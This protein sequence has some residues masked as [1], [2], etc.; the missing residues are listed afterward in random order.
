MKRKRISLTV[1]AEPYDE[2]RRLTK[3]IGWRDNW[4]GL[5]IDKMVAGALKVAAQAKIDAQK[6]KPDPEEDR[7]S[8]YEE[9]MRDAVT[10]K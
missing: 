10:R 8:R 9:I 1:N 3:E 4:L 7:I 6:E 5:E 2:L